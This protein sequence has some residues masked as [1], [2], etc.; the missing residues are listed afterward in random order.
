MVK[1]EESRQLNKNGNGLGLHICRHIAECMGGSVHLESE[2]GQGTKAVFRIAAQKVKS[3]APIGFPS[4]SDKA[5]NEKKLIRDDRMNQSW[6]T[7]TNRT[8]DPLTVDSLS[9]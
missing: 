9:V 2:Q 7:T 3:E 4:L 6:N 5:V 1:T 8:H